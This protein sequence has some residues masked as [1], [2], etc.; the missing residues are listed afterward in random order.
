MGLHSPFGYV[1][2]EVPLS[3][4]FIDIL[5]KLCAHCHT[6]DD[7]CE[8][9]SEC[10]AGILA[11][12]CRD[13][14]LETLEEDK[15]HELYASDEWEERRLTL[16]YPPTPPEEKE[17]ELRMA[18]EYKSE[19]EILRLMK[20]KIKGIKPHPIFYIRGHRKHYG[21]PKRLAD[22]VALTEHYKELRGSRLCKWGY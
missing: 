2:Y 9:C 8:G 4:L 7:Y 19:C 22:F 21:R 20:Q 1:S 10:P 3:E 15:H 6:N 5:D 16:C 11:L 13:Y 18:G 12:E 17:K 14:I